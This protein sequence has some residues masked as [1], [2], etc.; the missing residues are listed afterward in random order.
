MINFKDTLV[1]T[2]VP[3][4]ADNN[5]VT[6]VTFLKTA[7]AYGTWDGSKKVY[8]CRNLDQATDD[9]GNVD[10]ADFTVTVKG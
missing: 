3:E 10:S 2:T 9:C 4:D 7:H 8:N 1:L 5:E 6:G